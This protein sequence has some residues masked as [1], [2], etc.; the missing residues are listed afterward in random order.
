MSR[1]GALGC[2][3]LVC[4]AAMVASARAA[5]APPTLAVAA[6]ADLQFALGE[7]AVAFE[8]KTGSVVKLSFGA[9]GSFVA[10]ITAGAPFDLFFS[11]DEDY[12]KR[13]IEAGLALSKS[14]YRYADGRL[15]LWV[16]SDSPI[17]VAREGMQALLHPSVRRIALAN[18]AHAPYGR[19]AVAALRSSGL[20]DRL[21]SRLVFG[22]NISQAAQFVQSGNAEIGLLSQS[23]AVAP[24]LKERGRFW[25]VPAEAAPPLHQAVVILRRSQEGALAQSLIDFIKAKEGEGIL[26][27]H[28]FA[29][30]PEVK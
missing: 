10:Q 5:G 21:Q 16:P 14:F 25:L 29:L 23:Q 22:E 30:P 24:P 13:L 1:I 28:G 19:A 8:R 17:D 6:A 12:P 7:I 3:L 27:R 2:C 4:M 15:V 9:S 26:L 11:A 20:Y 18:P